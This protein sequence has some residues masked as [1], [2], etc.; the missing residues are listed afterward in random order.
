MI[1]TV[2]VICQQGGHATAIE[3]AKIIQ[4]T[5]ISPFVNFPSTEG[6]DV[7]ENN[8][9]LVN[10]RTNAVILVIS[11]DL[12]PAS[13]L[14]SN[15]EIGPEVFHELR[16]AIQNSTG[17]RIFPVL[18]DQHAEDLVSSSDTWLRDLQWFKDGPIEREKFRTN[19]RALSDA[20]FYDLDGS[21]SSFG[22]VISVIQ[23]IE[24]SSTVEQISSFKL[25]K[26]RI[27]YEV[28]SATNMIKDSKTYYVHLYKRISLSKTAVHMEKHLP[29]V[30]NSNDKFILLGI[31]PGQVRLSERLDNVKRVFNCDKVKYLENVVFELISRTIDAVELGG[32]GEVE[33]EFLDPQIQSGIGGSK[34]PKSFAEISSWISKPRS[35]VVVLQGQGGIGK[36]WAMLHLRQEVALGRIKFHKPADRSVVFI[37]STDVNRGVGAS[38]LQ[39]D[40]ISLYDL[41]VASCAAQSG[42]PTKQTWLSRETF[43]NAVEL[44]SLIV[45]LDGL[46]EIIARNRSRF[47]TASFFA[48]LAPYFSASSEAKIVITCRNTFFDLAEYR[49]SFPFVSTYELLAFDAHR[50]DQFFEDGL[51]GMSGRIQ[52]AKDLSDQISKLPDGRFVPFVL[53]LIKDMM[54]EKADG[55]ETSKILGFESEIL[56]RNDLNDRIIGQFCNREI[57]KVP[58]PLRALTVDQ[59]VK[60]FCAIARQNESGNG[61]S[62]HSAVSRILEKIVREKDVDS[63]FDHLVSHP[64]LSQEEYSNRGIL[65]LRFDFMPEY[66]LMLDASLGVMNGDGLQAGDIRIL[67]KYCNANSLFSAGLVNRYANGEEAFRIRLLELNVESVVVIH[68]T[69]P[70]QDLDILNHESALAQFSFSLV[71]LLSTFESRHGSLEMEPFTNALVE[72]FEENGAIR[73]MAILD[74]YFKEGQ[75]IKIDFRG[76]ALNNC[77]FHSVDIWNC[78][79]DDKSDFAQ[80]KFQHCEGVFSKD[81]GIS[82]ANFGSSCIVDETFENIWASGHKKIE[83][84]EAKIIEAVK[85]FVSDFH[86]Q[87]AFWKKNLENIERYYGQSNSTVPFKKMMRAMRKVGIISEKDMGHHIDV[88]ISK[89]AIASAEQLITQGLVNGPIERVVIA[90]EK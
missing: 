63:F 68:A 90:L 47:S 8:A 45:F 34:K 42:D 85:S 89:N 82:E 20:E 41:Y 55:N 48:D 27:G 74:G 87:G 10:Q 65:Q 4:E 69:M 76:L 31:E 51:H 12:F 23:G 40:E 54:L 13:K 24:L 5:G 14:K 58:D 61:A 80:C 88:T 25:A 70:S 72:I 75:R 67:N 1:P 3:Y 79:Y 53:S 11:A 77:L 33:R 83:T 52:K 59:Q 21:L 84:N 7:A 18:V 26:E 43:K 32:V 57:G 16:T 86:R 15:I 78:L 81:S 28:F 66:F 35:G 46:D 60:V 29:E 71:S 6:F 64:F 17:T 49:L 9:E 38:I 19:I 39:K 2:T 22:S 62:D 56:S 50:R 44:G 30:L 37:S 73:N 36:T